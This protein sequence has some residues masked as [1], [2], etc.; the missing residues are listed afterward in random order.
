[1][2]VFHGYEAG[3]IQ[4]IIGASDH[5]VQRISDRYEDYPRSVAEALRLLRDAGV[6][7][8]YAIALGPRCYAG[9][10]QATEHG[11]PVIELVRRLI[12]GPVIWA[13]AV[14]G[15][16][17]LSLRGGD[18]ELTV[19][20]DLSIGYDSH[21]E[22]NARLFLMESLTFRVLAGEAAVALRYAEKGSAKRA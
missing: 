1:S 8:P 2:V 5:P 10:T 11:Y 13:P 4:G 15:A 20:Q 9:L 16:V 12:D 7:G 22:K 18:F 19:G 14:D 21:D 17:V 6:D 3:G